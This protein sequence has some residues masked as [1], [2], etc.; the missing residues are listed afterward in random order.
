MDRKKIRLI[1]NIKDKKKNQQEIVGFVIIVL[2]V[3]IA[4]VILLAFYLRTNNS[5]IVTE[6]AELANFLA[7]SVQQTTP[8]YV[9]YPGN[10][11][12]LGDL[13]EACYSKDDS[14]VCEGANSC[15]YLEKSY[16]QF[17]IN[18]KPAGLIKAYS[19]KFCYLSLEDQNQ[20]DCFSPFLE[21]NS[22][23][24]ERCAVERSGRQSV[25]IQNQGEIVAQLRVCYNP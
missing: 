18:F 21:L 23:V 22:G 6:D 15:E 10:Y 25:D 20:S 24:I 16:S 8:C 5:T 14:V 2:L 12:S 4:G 19:L 11:R 17:L 1:A 13:I 7:S 9:D 3:I